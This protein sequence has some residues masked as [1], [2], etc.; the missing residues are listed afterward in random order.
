MRIERKVQEKKRIIV[1]KEGVFER[2][3]MDDK[4]MN[5][6]EEVIF[7]E[8]NERRIDEDLGMEMEIDVK[9]E[10]RED[11]KI[12]VM[13]EKMDGERVEQIIGD[14]KVIEREGRDYKVDIRYRERKEDE[15]IEDEMEREIRDE[16]VDEKGSI[17]ELMKGKGEIERKERIMEERMKEN[18]MIEKI[19]GE[20]EGREKDEE[21]RKENE[22]RRKIVMEKQIEEK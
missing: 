8:F 19:Y 9:E 12:I 15:R 11:I 6:V 21:I 10:M 22:G 1:V 2:M 18:V 14:E 16:M 5:G 3:I 20:M 17:M 13:Q 7:D 4:E